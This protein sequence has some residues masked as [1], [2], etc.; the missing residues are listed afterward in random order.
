MYC[1]LLKSIAK[2]R[3]KRKRFYPS[4]GGSIYL[5]M[6]PLI[7]NFLQCKHAQ[8]PPPLEKHRA[9]E[10]NFYGASDAKRESNLSVHFQPPAWL[11][12]RVINNNKCQRT[13]CI[14]YMLYTITASRL[15][16]QLHLQ[17]VV[18]IGFWKK[19]VRATNSEDLHDLTK[20]KS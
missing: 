14:R 4:Y 9:V 8:P 19:W 3:F 12:R 10:N 2:Q 13:K 15:L 11:K 16:L 5:F 1:M 6:S 18:S 20:E 7:T 17:H